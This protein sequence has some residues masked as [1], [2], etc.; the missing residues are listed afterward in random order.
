MMDGLSE[1][2]AEAGR[3]SALVCAGFV[4]AWIGAGRCSCWPVF[5]DS[6]TAPLS[7]DLGTALHDFSTAGRTTGTWGVGF[8]P[9]QLF[10]RFS[11]K[12][13]KMIKTNA[14]TT[15]NCPNAALAIIHS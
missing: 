9:G 6:C 4:S 8:A 1:T 15:T 2:S 10:L 11:I 7:V 13:H 12:P 14:K 3:A 5:C